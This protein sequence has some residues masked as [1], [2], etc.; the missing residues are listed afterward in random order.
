MTLPS[1]L[2]PLGALAF[3]LVAASGILFSLLATVAVPGVRFWPPGEKSWRYYLHWGLVAVFDVS[4]LAVAVLDWNTW[5]L[6]RPASLVAGAV[7]VVVGGVVFA[8]SSRVMDAAETAGLAGDLYTDGPYARS[9]NPQYVG[10]LV[11][12]AGFP[13]LVNSAAVAVLCAANVAWVLLLPLAEEPWLR[14]RFG[15]EYEAYRR[16][17]PRF[18]GLRSL[19]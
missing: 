14:E 15:E 6:P 1:T 13:L 18:V 9:R 16:S 11:G 5:L 12:L 3:G 2:P 19:R 17:V 4:T 8:R 7:F 10:M